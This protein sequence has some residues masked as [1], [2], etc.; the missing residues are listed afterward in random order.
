MDRDTSWK[1]ISKLKD[2][3]DLA[4]KIRIDSKGFTANFPTRVEKLSDLWP[5][6]ETTAPDQS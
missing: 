4:R 1:V 3:L 5:F 2:L 6:L